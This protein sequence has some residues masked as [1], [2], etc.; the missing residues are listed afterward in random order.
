[1]AYK[2]GRLPRSF[3]KRIP[4]YSMLA[5]VSNLP[6][7]PEAV[8]H[9]AKMPADFGMMG[10]A[11]LGDCTCAAYYH[12][13]QVWTFDASKNEVTEPDRHVLALYQMACGYVPGKPDT[14]QGGN[15][16]DVLK[17]LLNTGAPV[18]GDALA[19]NRI[20]A[21]FEIIASRQQDL[22]RAIYECG[23]AYIGINLPQSVMDNL[24]AVDDAIT[25][26]EEIDEWN[27]AH[28]SA[29]GK[30]KSLFGKVFAGIKDFLTGESVRKERVAVPD[31]IWDVSGDETIIGGHAVV[32]TS[33][34]KDGFTCI[35]WGKAYRV[36]N[37]FIAKFMEEAYAIVDPAWVD[38]TGKTPLGMTPEQ[39]ET[40]MQ[41]LRR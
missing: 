35:S 22:R 28:P 2:M 36:T 6:A 5:E 7:L 37:A 9:I 24:K 17:F 38:I 40:Q 16:Q 33:Y 11:T 8:D 1:M 20:L 27:A 3:D 32:L 41:S 14:D 13:R 23:V 26:N 21:Y 18:G 4:S 19:R 29:P 12:A 31:V 39:L 10:N 25:E 30:P 34:D 15:E